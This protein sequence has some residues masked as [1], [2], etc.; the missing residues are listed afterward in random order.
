M[1]PLRHGSHESAVTPVCNS[2][3]D[4]GMF[5]GDVPFPPRKR[6]EGPPSEGVRGLPPGGRVGRSATQIESVARAPHD[7]TAPPCN[8]WGHNGQA[9]V[10]TTQPMQVPHFQEGEGSQAACP[11]SRSIATTAN[12]CVENL[13]HFRGPRWRFSVLSWLA[14]GCGTDAPPSRATVLPPRPRWRP[15]DCTPYLL[16]C[17]FTSWGLS[18][19]DRQL[20]GAR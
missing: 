3:T 9:F 2:C 16:A 19:I 7:W 17:N 11:T 5:S 12:D 13:Q 15:P 10:G 1:C 4:R 8:A 18:E 6:S 14:D 20:A